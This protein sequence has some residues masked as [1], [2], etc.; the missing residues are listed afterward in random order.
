[1]GNISYFN[2]DITIFTSDNPRD[3]D[4]MKIINEMCADL[5]ELEHKQL[6]KI[7]ERAK[8]IER[9]IKLAKRN[10]IVLILGKGHE[11]YQEIKGVKYPFDDYDVLKKIL[12]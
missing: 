6:I 5:K 3:E 1:M 10:D 4:I 11:K 8:A 9:G 7:P 12:K 2:S